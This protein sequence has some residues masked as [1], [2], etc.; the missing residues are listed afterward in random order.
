MKKRASDE[1]FANLRALLVGNAAPLRVSDAELAAAAR[2]GEV[3]CLASAARPALLAHLRGDVERV[4]FF[5]IAL[6]DGLE[7]IAATFRSAGIT[8]VALLKGSGTC[9][10]LY[11]DTRM[12]QRRD[13]DLLVAEQEFEAALRA[14]SGA[15]WRATPPAA[16]WELDD[17]DRYEVPLR[18]PLGSGSIECDLHRRLTVWRI[19]PAAEAELLERATPRGTAPLPVLHPEDTLIH[20]ALQLATSSYAPPL[21]VWLDLALLARHEAVDLERVAHIA[22]RRRLSR[23]L[24]AAL[25]VVARWFG[26][27]LPPSI[28]ARLRPLDGT[29]TLLK[30]LL[31]GNGATPLSAGALPELAARQL[32]K[33]LALGDAPVWVGI[34]SQYAG[35]RS[36]QLERL[37]RRHLRW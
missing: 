12:R 26:V 13:I 20:V 32:A 6:S 11:T 23:P 2:A 15:G 17:R 21:K 3:V 9:F 5:D 4:V 30:A 25:H 18:W 10:Y 7:R 37:A 31:A 14:L 28:E 34:I 33:L 19:F 1:A 16:W 27:T 22:A 35:A 24:W 36:R 8:R 29:A